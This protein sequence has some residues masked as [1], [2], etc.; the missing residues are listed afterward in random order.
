MHPLVAQL[1]EQ[2]SSKPQDSGSSPAEGAIEALE[3]MA[4]EDRVKFFDALRDEF[5]MYCGSSS[6]RGCYCM[7]DD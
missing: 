4:P 2:Q 1:V 7:R 3:K 6:G 5:C